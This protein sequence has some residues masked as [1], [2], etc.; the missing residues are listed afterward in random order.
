MV[1][2]IHYYYGDGKGKTT[3]AIGQAIRSSNQNQVLYCQFL[4]KN[5]TN[6]INI[7]KTIKNIDVNVLEWNYPFTFQ[8]DEKQLADSKKELL[9]YFR[10]IEKKIASGAY[11]T[12][13][14]DEIGDAIQLGFL[15]E[16]LV[17]EFL[18]NRPKNLE[19]V[20]TGHQEI[21]SFTKLVDYQTFF[22]KEKHPYD[23]G[24][25]ARKGIEY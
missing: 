8:M 6:E 1:S 7:L 24:L 16:E 18:T 19:V 22:K 11:Q 14:L 17:L 10:E 4:K 2:C 23:Q 3:A 13:I 5:N 9:G 21:E 12:L 15:S 20:M 25:P